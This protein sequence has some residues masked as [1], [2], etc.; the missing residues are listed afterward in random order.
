MFHLQPFLCFQMI[1]ILNNNKVVKEL[2]ITYG[3]IDL[4]ENSLFN[5]FYYLKD[6][7]HL[8]FYYLLNIKEKPIYFIV[9]LVSYT[10]IFHKAIFVLIITNNWYL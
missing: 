5:K 6:W 1:C 9:N 8:I 3:F 4:K 2:M 10:K 7:T